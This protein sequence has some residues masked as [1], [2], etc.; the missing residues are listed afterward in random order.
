MHAHEHRRRR[1]RSRPSP[2]PGGRRGRC[3]SRRR[4]ARNSPPSAVGMVDSAARRTSFSLRRRYSIRSAIVTI[5]RPWR[6]ANSSRSGSRAIVPSSFMI[7]QITPAG[8]SPA[9]RARSTEPSVWPARRST[10]PVAGA[11]RED[12]ARAR[13]GRSAWR[14]RRSR[15]GSV[16]ARSAAEMPVVTPVARLD[17]DG[18]GGAEAR[19]VLVSGT[20]IG[21]RSCSSALLGERQADQA[22]PVRGHEVDRLGRHL[23]GRHAEVALVLA[24]LVVD[25]DDHLAGADVLEGRL[26][27]GDGGGDLGRARCASLRRLWAGL[28]IGEIRTLPYGPASGSGGRAASRPGAMTGRSRHAERSDPEWQHQTRHEAISAATPATPACE[29][30]D[31]RLAT[32]SRRSCRK[33]P[34]R[35]SSSRDAELLAEAVPLVDAPVEQRISSRKVSST[36]SPRIGDRREGRDVAPGVLDLLERLD[37]RQVALVELHDLRACWSKSMPFD[38]RFASM[39]RHEYALAAARRALRVGDEDDGVGAG[40]HDL[41]GRLV[42]HLAGHREE[43]DLDR[44]ARLRCRTRWAGSRSRACGRRLVSSVTILPARHGSIS[45][46]SCWRLVVLPGEGRPVVDHLHGDLALRHVDLYHR[47]RASRFP[48]AACGLLGPS[49]IGTTGVRVKAPAI[50]SGSSPAGPE[51]AAVGVLREAS[52]S[53]SRPAP[54]AQPRGGAEGVAQALVDQAPHPGPGLLPAPCRVL[55]AGPDGRPV[56]LDHGPDLRNAL[57]RDGARDQHPGP[58]AGRGRAQHPERSG[59]LAAGALGA[60]AL[61]A[62]GLVDHQRVGQLERRPS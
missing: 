55:A 5:L 48:G 27:R 23:L 21:R 37:V 35:K 34:L 61:L 46:C 26:D 25:E 19:A 1:A 59:V 36:P 28:V 8:S 57:P 39:S 7:S 15:P 62:V 51:A 22:A 30:P 24:V 29:H 41:A 53:R 11:Q 14:R 43:L 9:S 47:A 40:E 13:R 20:I 50:P 45:A 16:C 52:T 32:R 38:L 58:P 12:V 18:E 60:G 49:C 2:A 54:G 33:T 44:E 4:C 56:L 3:R 6:S 10:P 42:H 31:G 17:R